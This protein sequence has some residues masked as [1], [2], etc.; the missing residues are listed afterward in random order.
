MGAATVTVR[1]RVAAGL[2]VRGSTMWCSSPPAVVQ[3]RTRRSRAREAPGGDR[4]DRARAVERRGVVVRDPDRPA[5][6]RGVAGDGDVAAEGDEHAGA[7]R[8]RGRRG[9]AVGGAAPSRSRRDRAPRPA[10]HASRGVRVELDALAS[11]RRARTPA[12]SEPSVAEQEPRERPVVAGAA[13]VGPTVGSTSPPVALARPRRRP[14]P[15]E[16]QRAD[17]RPAR[18]RRGSA[19]HS[20]E[21][22]RKRLQARSNA[23]SPRRRMRRA[24]AKRG[25]VG[26]VATTA[27]VPSAR[28]SVATRSRASR[29]GDGRALEL[30]RRRLDGDGTCG[31]D[32]EDTCSDGAAGVAGH[33]HLVRS[34]GAVGRGRCVVVEALRP[35]RRCSRRPRATR[36]PRPTPRASDAGRGARRVPRA[37]V[38]RAHGPA[39]V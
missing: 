21:S 38:A 2:P 28:K 14:R 20:S 24:S 34:R 10:A 8:R 36:E 25:R 5:T 17:R 32:D 18:R 15:R 11:R 35:A 39:V 6:G 33:R 31:P 16:E 37:V 1:Q 26:D 12:G 23:R 7:G 9:R 19:P 13:E 30:W 4:D 22:W 3:R 29:D 27:V